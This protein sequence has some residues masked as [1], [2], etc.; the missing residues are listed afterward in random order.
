[1]ST[2][3]RAAKP[4]RPRPAQA[5]TAMGVLLLVARNKRMIA[6]WTCAAA[7]VGIAVSLLL[8][9]TFTGVTRIL[10]PQQGQ[11]TAAMM[12]GQL[13]GGLGALTGGSLGI[14]NPSDL[15]IGMLKSRTVADALIER[16]KLKELYEAKYLDDAR[17][18]LEK[19]SRFASDKSGIITIQA[20]AA[21]PK[22]AADLAN[23][24]VEQLHKL[25][26]TLAISEAAQRRVFFERQTQQTKDKLADAEVKLRQALDSGGLVS[27]DAQGR[28]AVETVARLRGQI[29]A[30]EI[31]IGAMKGYAAPS[32]PDLQRA[33]KELSSMRQELARLESG[34]PGSETVSGGD[35]KGMGHIRL[36]REVKYNEALFEALAKQYELARVE[37]AMEAPL[38]QVLDKAAPPEKKSGPKRAQIVILAT[39]GGFV[40]AVLA[41]LAKNALETARQDPSFE[42]QLSALR[43][44]WSRRKPE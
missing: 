1:M 7:V 42:A 18:R 3:P 33:E 6:G 14:K 28:A 38:V 31:Q 36:M 16:F 44:A 25:T 23:A 10:P 40:A 21:D 12:L 29:S 24:Y 34:G 43:A 32:N 5:V 11:S 35:V 8:P 20:D 37:E 27:V 15:Y 22:L 26:T 13:G 2:E 4:A 41:A 39:L 19:D 9:K 30:K 17:G